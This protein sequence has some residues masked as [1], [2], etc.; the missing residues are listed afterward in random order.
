MAKLD[1]YCITTAKKLAALGNVMNIKSG[2]PLR[3]CSLDTYTLTVAIFGHINSD[4]TVFNEPYHIAKN[5]CCI[6]PR[7]LLTN[8]IYAINYQQVM[9]K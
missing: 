2:C 4:N 1:G 9:I 7:A 5:I 8:K 6:M 3:I